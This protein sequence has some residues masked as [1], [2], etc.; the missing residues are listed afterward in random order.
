[1]NRTASHAAASALTVLI[2]IAALQP[3]VAADARPAWQLKTAN[4]YFSVYS[5]YCAPDFY[6]RAASPEAPSSM[7]IALYSDAF[8][9]EYGGDCRKFYFGEIATRLDPDRIGAVV[10]ARK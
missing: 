6:A 4:A 1:M 5:H 7:E 2:G 10:L 9:A 3:V 8:R